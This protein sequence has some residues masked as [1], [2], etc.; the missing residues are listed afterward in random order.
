MKVGCGALVYNSSY[1]GVDIREITDPSQP[2]QKGLLRLPSQCIKECVVEPAW[3]SSDGRRLKIG[4]SS[5][6]SSWA[7][8]PDLCPSGSSCRA[9]A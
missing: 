1:L 7:K 9:P 6:R 5:Y 8:K 3:H 4:E 2:G